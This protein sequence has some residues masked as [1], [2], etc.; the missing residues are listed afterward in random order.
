MHVEKQYSI[1]NTKNHNTKNQNLFGNK[2]VSIDFGK[3][4]KSV[5]VD[6]P[7]MF[8]NYFENK[9]TRYKFVR[10]NISDIINERISLVDRSLFEMKFVNME[11][12]CFLSLKINEI[13]HLTTGKKIHTNPILYKFKDK[14]NKELQ[15]Y[16]EKKDVDNFEVKFIDIY[17]LVIPAPNRDIG[18]TEEHSQETYEYHKY[19]DICLSEIKKELNIGDKQKELVH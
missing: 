15:Y 13:L 5:N 12:H 3:S 18:E 6:E 7:Y 17:H 10:K 14:I 8:T 2:N 11:K 19:D 9:N 16:V 4:L 1:K